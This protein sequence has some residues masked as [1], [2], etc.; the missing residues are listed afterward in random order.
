MISLLEGEVIFRSPSFLFSVHGNIFSHQVVFRHPN[1]RTSNNNFPDS[2]YQTKMNLIVFISYAVQ[3]VRTYWVVCGCCMCLSFIQ[4]SLSTIYVFS[5]T[6]EHPA[7]TLPWHIESFSIFYWSII[8]NIKFKHETN[9]KIMELEKHSC[10]TMCDYSIKLILE[11][12]S[13]IFL[14]DWPSKY[15]GVDSAE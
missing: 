8:Q 5:V 12:S 15:H 11:T 6:I 10:M 7:F 2:F 9:M 4:P 13:Y 3:C 14:F 1:T